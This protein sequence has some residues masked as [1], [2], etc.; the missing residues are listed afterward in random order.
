MFI[1]CYPKPRPAALINIVF[2]SSSTRIVTTPMQRMLGWFV[3]CTHHKLRS[4]IRYIS[5]K[6]QVTLN[7]ATHE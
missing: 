7:C 5:V 3:Y 4:C 1:F 6:V 2:D